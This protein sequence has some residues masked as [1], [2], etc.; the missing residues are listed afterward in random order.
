MKTAAMAFVGLL[1]SVTLTGCG[2]GD[3]E[4]DA[5]AELKELG[6]SKKLEDCAIAGIKKEAGSLEKFMDLDSSKQQSIAAQA[7][8]DCAENISED[9]FGDLAENLDEGGGV[10]FND[11]AFRKSFIT[12]MTGQGVPESVANCILD[13]MVDQDLAMTDVADPE[14]MARLAQECQ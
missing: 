6:F 4:A 2:G 11:P 5:R 10:D 3:P 7:G 9:E 1:L 8:A 12:G 14:I 13:K